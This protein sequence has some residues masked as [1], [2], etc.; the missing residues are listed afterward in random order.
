M[1]VKLGHIFQEKKCVL[2]AGNYGIPPVRW[3]WDDNVGIPKIIECWLLMIKC[4][5]SIV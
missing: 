2:W 4:I 5:W 1:Q 3:Q